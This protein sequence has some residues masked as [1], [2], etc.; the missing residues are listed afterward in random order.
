MGRFIV[1]DTPSGSKTL[2]Y[3]GPPEIRIH[4]AYDPSH[5]AERAAASFNGG[6]ATAILVCGLGLGYHIAAL[7]GRFPD[8]I[9]IALEKDPEVVR[10]ARATC[11]TNLEGAH[12]IV[13]PGEIPSLLESFDID[14]FRGKAVFFHRPSYLLAK[15][16]Y[17]SMVADISRYFSSKLSDLLT[18]FEF[19]ER[20]I[21]NIFANLPRS[22]DAGRVADLFGKFSGFPGIIVSAGPSL[23]KNASTLGRLRGRALII[24]VDTALKV[25]LRHGVEPHI[26]MTIDAQ[27]HSIKHFLG[28]RPG[29][30]VL[31]A[32]MVS[33][34]RIADV[35]QGKIMFSTTAK[36]YNG[37]D[38]GVRREPTPAMDWVERYIEPPGDI[39]SGG[40]VA[41]SAFDLLLNLGCSPIVL[42]GQ[43]LAY[44]GR[45]IHSTGTHHNAEWL[46]RTTRFLNLDGIN[47]GVIR[48]RKIKYVEA[49][50]G[51]GT[52]ISDYVF[53]LYRN[54]FEDSARKVAVPV[55]NASGDGA[56]IA[57]TIERSLES[58]I[59]EFPVR[60]PGPVEVLHRY[61]TSGTRSARALRLALEE[62]LDATVAA[63]SLAAVPHGDQS[64]AQRQVL[65]DTASRDLP[66]LF[67]PFLRRTN[68][69]L[70]RHGELSAERSA[71]ILFADIA[72]AA[73]KLQRHL[74]SCRAR[75]DDLP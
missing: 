69:Y 75:I 25:L 21:S 42:V 9:V 39:Q 40:S 67:S 28:E 32:D 27:K 60:N 54:W 37:P 45:E 10:L 19:E 70:A 7:R 6:R 17:D 33:Y 3:T 64:D 11:P 63:A 53:D 8:R 66:E 49:Y 20:W 59:N 2:V 55:I 61:L 24:S 31:L 29:G 57:N 35:Y 30:T 65:L 34:P 1:N 44:T 38:G 50:G 26:V 68:A 41:T 13:S 52:V 48:K 36:Y 46:A 14:T 62:A 4:S 43:D 47:Q 15:D 22:F 18:R 5:E 56:R 16:F 72:A 58:L 23:R 12:I 71:G 74:A 51:G 73:R